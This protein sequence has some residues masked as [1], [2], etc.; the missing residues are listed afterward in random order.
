MPLT[1]EVVVRV[2]YGE[3]DQMG[4]VYH[5]SYIAY[6]EC[7]RTEFLRA[8][9]IRYRDM[10]GE[11]YFL[12]VTEVG[13]RYRSPGRYDDEL[14]V[15]ARVVE[16]GPA[17]VRFAYEVRRER[18]AELLVEGETLLACVGEDRRPRRLPPDVIEKLKRTTA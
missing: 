6:F 14:R 15:A 10:E 2:R 4:V 5:G 8:E 18:E 7:A 16:H 12:V 13:I 17:S 9:G 11:G 3:T 1:R